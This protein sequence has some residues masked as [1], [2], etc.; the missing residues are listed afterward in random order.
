M[1]KLVTD[2]LTVLLMQEEQRFLVEQHE[3]VLL[4]REVIGAQKLRVL[5]LA[6]NL[7]VNI[8]RQYMATCITNNLS[9]CW[10]PLKLIKPQR[11]DET[12]ISVTVAKAEKID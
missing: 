10:E 8:L 12:S 7:D 1:S 2:K 5:R 11:N 3:K 6:E 4:L 9:N